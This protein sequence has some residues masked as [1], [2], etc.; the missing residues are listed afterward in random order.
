V[1]VPTI[2]AGHEAGLKQ[3][4]VKGVRGRVIRVIL[5][6]NTWITHKTFPLVFHGYT[7]KTF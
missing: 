6:E 4:D 7:E 3:V 5:R 2:I 1:L